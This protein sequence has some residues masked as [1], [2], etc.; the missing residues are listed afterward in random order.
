[1]NIYLY[2]FLIN[3]EFLKKPENDSDIDSEEDEDPFKNH[4]WDK[5]GLVY[6][7]LDSPPPMLN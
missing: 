5:M 6:V 1:M 3:K 7:K 4:R 2:L